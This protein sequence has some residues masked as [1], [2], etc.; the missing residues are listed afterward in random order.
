[1]QIR[2]KGGMKLKKNLLLWNYWA[3]LNHTLLKWSLGGPLSKLCP[4]VPSCIQEPVSYSFWNKGR[5]VLKFWKFD[6]KREITPR[7]VT[8]FTS[9]LQGPCN[10]EVNLITHLGVI[11]LFH[12][13]FF[14]N[15]FLFVL[16]FKNYLEIDVKFKL[17]KC[18]ACHF[19]I[20][21]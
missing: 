8:R 4:S 13:F 5:K 2:K 3:N 18:A 11:A 1:M 15:L 7:W 16:Y 20:A 14:F 19:K 9:K 6:E 17:Q 21:G 12:Q 10:F